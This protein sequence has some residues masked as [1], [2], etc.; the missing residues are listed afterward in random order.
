MD[1]LPDPIVISQVAPKLLQRLCCP[2]CK[3]ALVSQLEGLLCARCQRSYPVV[4]GI[5]DLRV[6]SDPYVTFEEDHYKG[7]QVHEQAQRLSFPE[8]LRFYWENVS[9]PPTAVELRERFIRHV[10][11]DEERIAG[12][13]EQLGTGGAFLD[14][15]CG[16][17]SLVKA[18][19]GLFGTVIGCDVAFRW[20]ILARKR[21]EEAQVPANLVCCCA[22]YL[23]FP[24]GSFD[25]VAT[26]SVLE[27][28]RAAP[29][30]LK[31]CARVAC[32]GGRIFVLTTNRFS[33]APEPHVRVWGVGFLPR[34]WMPAYVRWRRGVAY[35][36][37]RLLSLFEL[38]RFLKAAECDSLSFR[39]PVL[40]N[41]DLEHASSVE[42]LG[43]RIFSFLGRLPLVRAFLLLVSPVIQVLARRSSRPVTAGE[44]R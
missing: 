19:H 11:T 41:R 1:S 25:T 37:H 2:R 40:A 24:D 34:R 9:Q 44:A 22:D 12:Y 14:V 16:A 39:L 3:G 6:Y 32:E 29:A 8:L 5:P 21:L 17:G 36:K 10:L 30:V 33:I 27:H 31:D 18:A 43:A 15:G 20:L 42:R 38:R 4:L 23:P 35:D 13:L 28:V 26:V 7:H